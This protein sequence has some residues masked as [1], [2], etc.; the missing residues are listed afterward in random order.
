MWSHLEIGN[1]W[2]THGTGIDFKGE[3]H[4]DTELN[5]KGLFVFPPELLRCQKALNQYQNYMTY[6]ILFL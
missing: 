2:R 3:S 6:I 1:Y 4:K 5:C